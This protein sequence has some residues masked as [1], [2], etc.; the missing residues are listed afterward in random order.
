MISSWQIRLRS[1]GHVAMA[2]RS[3]GAS[4]PGCGGLWWWELGSASTENTI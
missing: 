1:H 2:G 4:E 3:G